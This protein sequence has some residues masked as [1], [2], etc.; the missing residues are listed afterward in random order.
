LQS[1]KKT[2]YEHDPEGVYEMGSW[3][4]KY[5]AQLYTWTIKNDYL[6]QK[7]NDFEVGVDYPK[8]IVNIELE[9]CKWFFMENEKK[10]ACKKKVLAFKITYHGRYMRKWILD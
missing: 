3:V 5:S 8:P 6:D 10:S 1:N 9:I 4:A 7:F 2:S